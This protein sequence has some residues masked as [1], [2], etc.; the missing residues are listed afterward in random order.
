M[1]HCTIGRW[2]EDELLMLVLLYIASMRHSPSDHESLG[3]KNIPCYK[4]DDGRGK[5][6]ETECEWRSSSEQPVMVIN[7]EVVDRAR[8]FFTF[9]RKIQARE[10]T[11]EQP[12]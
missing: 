10:P 8:L 11:K 6:P 2:F 4:P 1:G 7:W 12:T 5:S 9:V 3:P